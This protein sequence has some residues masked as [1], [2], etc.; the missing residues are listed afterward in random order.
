MS[1]LACLRQFMYP[2]E[3]R[4][5]PMKSYDVN[6]ILKVIANL[7]DKGISTSISE[8]SI[9]FLSDLSLSLW[10]LEKKMTKPGADQPLD[11]MT[12]AYACLTSI[13]N[14]LIQAGVTV[15]EHT[16]LLYE[17]GLPLAVMGYEE[18]AGISEP[19]IIKT[20]KPAV[21]LHGNPV[22]YGEIIVG[23]PLRKDE[24]DEP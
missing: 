14:I 7:P 3:F 16:G 13:W 5:S 11:E 22:Q 10:R 6:T 19:T 2:P 9:R 8:E 15:R 21:Y 17:S 20:I 4:I 12:H 1:I 23:L 18:I 24:S